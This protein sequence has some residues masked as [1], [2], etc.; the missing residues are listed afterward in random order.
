LSGDRHEIEFSTS[1]LRF[2]RYFSLASVVPAFCGVALGF[3]NEEAWLVVCTLIVWLG[4]IT[5]MLILVRR[6]EGLPPL[7]PAEARN[8]ALRNTGWLVGAAM[9][10]TTLVLG[11]DLG[12]MSDSV[13]RLVAGLASA[14]LL[15][16]AA[17]ILRSK[18]R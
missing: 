15:F 2:I 5:G 1:A 9:I 12:G 13:V 8:D 11:L 18:S 17:Y 3:R 10:L 14:A 16:R 6:H 7:A 4:I